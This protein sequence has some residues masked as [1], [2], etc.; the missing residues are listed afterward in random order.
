MKFF[1]VKGGE[2]QGVQNVMGVMMSDGIHTVVEHGLDLVV[3]Q[4]TFWKSTTKHVGMPDG[5]RPKF[6]AE[7]YRCRISSLL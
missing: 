7:I 4:L 5:N 2:R 3:D 6:T 1:R